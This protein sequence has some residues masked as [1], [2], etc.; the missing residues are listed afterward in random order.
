MKKILLASVGA[1]LA[2]SSV[3]SAV[4]VTFA[5]FLQ[6]NSTNGIT[7]SWNGS[8]GSLSANY[9]VSFLF[10]VPVAPQYTGLLNANLILTATSTTAP[11]ND[12]TNYTENNFKGTIKLIGTGA[13]AGVNL[14]TGNFTGGPSGGTFSGGS[15]GSAATFN[16]ATPLLTELVYSSGV[17]SFPTPV[18]QAMALSFSAGN[19]ALPSSGVTSPFTNTYSA[20]GTFSAEPT[21]GVPEPATFVLLGAGLVGLAVARRKKA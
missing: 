20:S 19:P 18:N 5:Q 16:V 9:N 10:L 3:G 7:Y 8:T 21:P 6:Q 2:F 17:L 1:L 14:L 13:N 12:G 4:P 11:T 15:G